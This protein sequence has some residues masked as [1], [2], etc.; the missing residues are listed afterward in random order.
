[1]MSRPSFNWVVAQLSQN[2]IFQS[3]GSKPQRPVDIQLATFL[4]RYGTQGSDVTGTSMKVGIGYGTVLLYCYRVTRA[5]RELRDRFVNFPN[6]EDQQASMEYIER[7]NGFKN[8]IHYGEW[9]G[10]A[11]LKTL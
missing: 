5:L 2:P 6:E 11:L 9:V 3:R 8:C 10:L 1:R 7:R 4:I